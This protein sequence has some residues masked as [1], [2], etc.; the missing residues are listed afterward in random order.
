MTQHFTISSNNLVLLSQIVVALQQLG[1]NV[2]GNVTGDVYNAASAACFTC[3]T[4]S[5]AT[6]SAST[7]ASITPASAAASVA[8]P[9]PASIPITVAVASA[10][11]S[12]PIA[13]ATAFAPVLAPASA[14]IAASYPVLTPVMATVPVMATATTATDSVT[15]IAN[16]NNDWYAIMVGRTVGIF[17]AVELALL[18]LVSVDS[19]VKKYS[20]WEDGIDTFEVAE[21]AGLIK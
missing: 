5:I 8:A 16:N 7:S 12:T 10:S 19:V 14:Q 15:T 9:A 18:L 13:A 17:M 11:V 1:I 6:S 4:H 21:A 3:H 2:S 20:N